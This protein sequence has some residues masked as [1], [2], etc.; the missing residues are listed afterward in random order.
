MGEWVQETNWKGIGSSGSR[1]LFRGVSPQREAE[2]GPQKGT[3]SE[4]PRAAVWLGLC[5]WGWAPGFND[6]E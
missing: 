2:D 6:W 1:Q 3:G 5:P 4:A